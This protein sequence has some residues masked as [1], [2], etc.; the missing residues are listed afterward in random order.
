MEHKMKRVVAVL[1]AFVVVAA[2]AGGCAAKT[3][4]SGTTKTT[5]GATIANP[6]RTYYYCGTLNAH[7]YFYDV[8][9]GFKWAANELNCTIYKVGPDTLDPVAQTAAIQ[10]TIAK[11]P[12]GIITPLYDSSPIPAIKSAMSAG[13]PVI[14][15][16]ANVEGDNGAYAYVGADNIAYGE[17]VGQ[18][19]LKVG[20]S[21]KI[22]V[23]GNW[24]ANN[25]DQNLQG[26]TT[27]IAGSGWTI[28]GKVDDKAT[29]QDAIT[30]GK[31]AINNYPTMT[32][33]VGM[34]SSS[35]GGIV[36]AMKELNKPAGSYTVVCKDREDAI[37]QGIQDG[38]IST[39]VI[40]KSAAMAYQAVLLLQAYNNFGMDKIPV[41]SD[42]KAA[43]VSPMAVNNFVGG[44]VIT[45]A[46]VKYFLSSNI[47]EVKSS[48][49]K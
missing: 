44:V 1:L 40:N 19:L 34:D 14:V 33:M 4:T 23:C 35:G 49:F 48:L 22:V 10:Q 24:G 12:N 13:I 46:N 27:A 45:K 26:F 8:Y 30:A 36:E 2:V 39:A 47:P 17:Q 11:K 41:S 21:G 28:I 5:T 15:L 6:M 7:P 37:L 32:C 16:E 38:Y 42:N 20:T 18:E 31:T 25:T 3:A 9:Q 43:G 29:S